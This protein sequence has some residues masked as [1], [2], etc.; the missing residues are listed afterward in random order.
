M[1]T[2]GASKVK[3]P[4][5]SKQLVSSEIHITE[6]RFTFSLT[7]CVLSHLLDLVLLSPGYYEKQRG[8]LNMHCNFEIVT[9]L[10][11]KHE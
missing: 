11:N 10:V 2:T 4:I 1:I 6:N 3:H 8:L 9:S 5:P 7:L